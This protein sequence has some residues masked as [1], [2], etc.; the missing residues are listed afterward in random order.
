MVQ[1]SIPVYLYTSQQLKEAVVLQ[2]HPLPKGIQTTK[3]SFV[4]AEIEAKGEGILGVPFPASH[5]AK[6]T[7]IWYKFWMFCYLFLFYPYQTHTPLRHWAA[8]ILVR[9]IVTTILSSAC[10][11]TRL[12]YICYI[13]VYSR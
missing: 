4:W 10:E 6:Y 2:L 1:I 11:Q 5:F 12:E 8:E 9:S 13:M 3:A 7:P